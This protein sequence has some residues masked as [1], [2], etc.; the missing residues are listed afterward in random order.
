MIKNIDDF[1]NRCEFW[2]EDLLSVGDICKD[3]EDEIKQLKRIV[4]LINCDVAC[5]TESGRAFLCAIDLN[6]IIDILSDGGKIKKLSEVN[7]DE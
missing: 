7:F 5:K 4:E 3:D 1:K 6:E 2:F